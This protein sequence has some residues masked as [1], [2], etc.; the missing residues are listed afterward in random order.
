MT[1]ERIFGKDERCSKFF[2]ICDP[3]ALRHNEGELT[4]VHDIGK[5]NKTQL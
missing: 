1:L 2:N 3:F 4:F 5:A